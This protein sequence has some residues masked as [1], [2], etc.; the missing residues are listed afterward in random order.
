MVDIDREISPR[1][2][3]G[4]TQ[5]GTAVKK[6]FVL[7][8]ECFKGILLRAPGQFDPVPNTACVWVGGEFVTAD[9]VDTGGMPIAPGESLYIPVASSGRLF[10]V[11]TVEAQDI[12]WILT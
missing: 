3:H 1:L 11:S 8:L 5:V 7:D 9:S 2:V 10:V 4:H 12:A 6:L